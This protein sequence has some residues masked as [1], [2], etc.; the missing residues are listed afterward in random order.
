MNLSVFQIVN[1]TLI[2]ALLVLFTR[3]LWIVFFSGDRRPVQWTFFV[4]SGAVSPVI[5]QMKRRYP[6]KIRFYNWWIQVERLKSQKVEGAFV[7]LGVYKGESARILHH[8]D[9]A[10]RFHLFD[11]FTGFEARDLV[12]ETGQ[13]A[14]Y[15][16]DNFAD[17]DIAMVLKRIEGN[18]NVILH[19]GY[20]PDT[21]S[22]FNEPVAL[23]SMD[24]DLFNPTS[25]GLGLFYPLL[26][27]GGVIMVHDYNHKWP[28]II[29]AVDDFVQTIPESLILLPDIDGTAM[30]IRNK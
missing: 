3:Y 27:P 7:E 8:L 4:K 21:A 20:F 1:Y 25:A 28:G 5:K 15:T 9:P 18:Q 30:I 2:L 19:P 16:P 14:T 17:T 6:D 11:T 24:A 12:V 13:A 26:T 23:V 29:K 22:G 10:R